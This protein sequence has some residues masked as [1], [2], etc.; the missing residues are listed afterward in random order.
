MVNLDPDS[1]ETGH[2]IKSRSTNL[3]HRNSPHTDYLSALLGM[4][5]L[6]CWA[7][8]FILRSRAW[9]YCYASYS[10]KRRSRELL[11]RDAEKVKNGSSFLLPLYGISGRNCGCPKHRSFT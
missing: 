6:G 10:D 1:S 11:S 4:S 7:C 8:F 9:Q 5:G 2:F 3:G